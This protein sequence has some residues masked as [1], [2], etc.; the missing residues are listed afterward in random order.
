M[1]H[2][3]T[4]DIPR[5]W[6][7]SSNQRLHWAAKAKRTKAVRHAA[8]IAA[9]NAQLPTF[10]TVAV[11]AWIGYPRN[12]TAD[13]SNAAPLVK[14]ALDGCTDAAIWP[15]DNSEHVVAVTYRRD[16]TTKRPGMHTLRLTITDQEVPF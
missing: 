7:L 13:P 3:F 16:V 9:R 8:M 2:E 4:I 6:W 14:A 1:S 10:Q 15:D 5:E 12:G 11:C